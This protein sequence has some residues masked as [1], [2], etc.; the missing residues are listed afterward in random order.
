MKLKYKTQIK[1]NI[2]TNQNNKNIEKLR[3]KT[4]KHEISKSRTK[5]K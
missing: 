5:I 1:Q 4:I 2:T 3:I